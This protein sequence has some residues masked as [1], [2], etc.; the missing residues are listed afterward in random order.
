MDFLLRHL[1]DGMLD[2]A[3]TNTNKLLHHIMQS[4]IEQKFEMRND[5]IR[6]TQP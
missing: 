2:P 3:H 4:Q 6:E 1:P 5:A